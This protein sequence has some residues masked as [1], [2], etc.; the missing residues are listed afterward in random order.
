[1]RRF[2]L[3]SACLL[4][5]AVGAVAVQAA[6]SKGTVSRSWISTTSGGA[7]V[8]AFSATKGKR[9]YANFVWKTPA[10]PGQVLRIE[11]RDPAG[12]LRAVWRNKTIKN[13]KKGTRLFAWIGGGLVKG[14]LGT[15]NAVLT[16]GGTPISSHHFQVT[17]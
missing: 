2:S 6:G 16:V 3:L 15:W 4:A 5:L 14:K 13:D 12:T 9:L 17:A 11:W 8:K 1:M 10:T 7:S